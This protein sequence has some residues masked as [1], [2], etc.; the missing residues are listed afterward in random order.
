MEKLIYALVVS[1]QKL[2]PYFEPYHVDALANE[3]LIMCL[4]GKRAILVEFLLKRSISE[5]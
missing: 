3:A 5:G 4:T 2:R 1:T